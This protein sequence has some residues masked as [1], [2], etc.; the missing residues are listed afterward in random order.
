M[1]KAFSPPHCWIFQCHCRTELA[2]VQVRTPVA[3]IITLSLV[4]MELRQKNTLTSV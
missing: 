2:E 1:L 4:C 3:V